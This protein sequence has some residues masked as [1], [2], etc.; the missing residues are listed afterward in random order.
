[1]KIV[2]VV[3]GRR[4]GGLAGKAKLGGHAASEIGRRRTQ[5]E[6]VAERRL[7]KCAIK[8][9]GGPIRL[10]TVTPSGNP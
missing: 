4:E 9:Q 5:S 3:R 2:V 8:H 6:D 7:V 1:M 10:H